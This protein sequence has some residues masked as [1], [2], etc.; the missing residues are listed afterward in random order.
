MRGLLLSRELGQQRVHAVGQLAA[1]VA[2]HRCLG[3]QRNSPRALYDGSLRRAGGGA[4]GAVGRRQ[5]LR[6]EAGRALLHVRA[7]RA[8]PRRRRPCACCLS[9]AVPSFFFLCLADFACS[10]PEHTKLCTPGMCCPGCS[11]HAVGLHGARLPPTLCR[12]CVVTLLAWSPCLASPLRSA[13]HCRPGPAAAQYPGRSREVY[14]SSSN[15]AEA[16]TCDVEVPTEVLR[17]GCSPSGGAVLLDGRDVGAYDARW[18]RRRV[19]LVSQARLRRARAQQG[20]S[21]HALAGRPWSPRQ[22]DRTFRVHPQHEALRMRACR[23]AEPERAT[24]SAGA[25]EIG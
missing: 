9:E 21:L 1:V 12:P 7:P 20:R 22:P 14:S 19:A 25:V 5:E 23:R 16:L 15:V 10:R 13:M 18:L 4:G 8:R 6:R 2:H 17:A 24:A 3:V 11:A